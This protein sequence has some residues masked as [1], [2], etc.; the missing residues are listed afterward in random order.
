MGDEGRGGGGRGREKFR[1]QKAK[2]VMGKIAHVPEGHIEERKTAKQ[3][4]TEQNNKRANTNSGQ[5]NR[6][7]KRKRMIYITGK[8]QGNK[9]KE[10]DSAWII[11]LIRHK[12]QTRYYCLG[13]QHNKLVGCNKAKA[14]WFWFHTPRLLWRHSL[15]AR[16]ETV[17]SE[18][19]PR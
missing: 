7:K 16:A 4:I 9:K 8:N 3:N 19:R 1:V 15:T 2:N 13:R 18:N 6:L 10:Q 17:E 5:N 12:L 14:W 11:D